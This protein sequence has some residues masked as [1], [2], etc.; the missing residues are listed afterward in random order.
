MDLITTHLEQLSQLFQNSKALWVFSA[1]L[2]S[3]IVGSFLNVVISR[4]PPSIELECQYE[5]RQ[6]LGIEEPEETLNTQASALSALLA[7]SHCPTC[8]TR[9]KLL[10]NIPVISYIFLKGRCA[11]CNTFIS[12]TYPCVELL[13]AFLGGMVA[14]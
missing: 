2:L 4:L 14:A 9:L 7:P 12:P 11:F 13:T 1:A 5:C 8:K 3:M 10:H 6:Y